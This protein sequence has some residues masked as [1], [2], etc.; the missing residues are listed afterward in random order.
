MRKLVEP[1]G[2]NGELLPT[3]PPL[4]DETHPHEDQQQRCFLSPPTPI[5]IEPRGPSPQLDLVQIQVEDLAILDLV[6]DIGHVF[7]RP[8]ADVEILP[9]ATNLLLEK[10][11][12]TMD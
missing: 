11:N 8:H 7:G 2:E 6:K 12:D 4:F 3:P 5:R 9:L 1:A 10:T